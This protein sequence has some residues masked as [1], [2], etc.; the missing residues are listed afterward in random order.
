MLL[1]GA[2]HVVIDQANRDNSRWADLKLK[3]RGKLQ[4]LGYNF[5]SIG[6]TGL[7]NQPRFSSQAVRL[8]HRSRQSEI[9]VFP[10]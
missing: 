5:T 8:R 2:L 4:L 9:A 6:S 1:P 7:Y 3:T 10:L